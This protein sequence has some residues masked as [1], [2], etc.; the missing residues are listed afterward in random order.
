MH[1]NGNYQ[2]T[3]TEQFSAPQTPE[4]RR[5]AVANGAEFMVEQAVGSMY[6]Q[7]AAAAEFAIN[8]YPDNADEVAR[9]STAAAHQA[10]QSAI[11]GQRPE[12]N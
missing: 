12:V 4:A 11:A 7:V 2:T 1:N 9:T 10:I 8:G 3:R 5:S 6:P